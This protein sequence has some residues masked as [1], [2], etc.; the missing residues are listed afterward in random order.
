LNLALDSLTLAD[1]YSVQEHFFFYAHGAGSLS[2]CRA[3]A[4]GLSAKRSARCH[5]CVLVTGVNKTR[6]AV[7]MNLVISQT[8]FPHARRLATCRASSYEDVDN[9]ERWVYT[10]THFAN[11]FACLLGSGTVRPIPDTWRAA[12]AKSILIVDDLAAVRKAVRSF[13]TEFGFAVCGEAVD[14][15][16]AIQ[17]AEELKP[18]LIL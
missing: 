2:L 10:R 7:I 5:R 18:D 1:D 13:L 12:H 4:S 14:G 6:A 16:D 11:R 3:V 15:Y 8:S 9:T 17:K